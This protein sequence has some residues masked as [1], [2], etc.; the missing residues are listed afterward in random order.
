MQTHV[1]T[2]IS[3]KNGLTRIKPFSEVNI[4]TSA[5]IE[6]YQACDLE[7]KNMTYSAV[8]NK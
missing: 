6:K 7:N 2:Y 4:Y 5:S 3:N 1:W 8:T